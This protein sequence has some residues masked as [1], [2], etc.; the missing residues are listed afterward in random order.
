M[1]LFLELE[2]KRISRSERNAQIFWLSWMIS[3]LAKCTS[4]ILLDY[5]LL[6][7]S[8]KLHFKLLFIPSNLKTGLWTELVITTNLNLLPK[9]GVK[10]WKLSIIWASLWYGTW[11]KEVLWH[12]VGSAI[13]SNLSN[14]PKP[15]VFKELWAIN[16]FCL[17]KKSNNG[18]NL[19]NETIRFIFDFELFIFNFGYFIWIS[20]WYHL[21]YLY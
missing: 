19:I 21:H 1:T 18:L 14:E 12:M 13:Q 11:K 4:V 5:C 2:Q 9:L 20:F 3:Q 16:L 8:K 7:S 15:W 6:S 17:I 10:C